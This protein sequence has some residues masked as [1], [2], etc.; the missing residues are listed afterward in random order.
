MSDT[1][2]RF[3]SNRGITQSTRFIHTPGD[4][5]LNNLLYVQEAGALKSLRPHTSSREGLESILF[6]II[7]DGEGFVRV[8]GNEYTVKS[9]DCILL[10]CM[11]KYEHESSE[12]KPWELSWVHFYG[13]TAVN[14]YDLFLK[15]NKNSNIFTP[16]ETEGYVKMIENLMALCND[17]SVMSEIYANETLTEMFTEIISD[18]TALSSEPSDIDVSMA[19]TYLNDNYA[20]DKAIDEICEKL[21]VEKEV[22]ENAFTDS[23]GISMAE[24]QK[25]RRL[26]VAKEMLRFS[27]EPESKIALECGINDYNDFIKLFVDAEG[28][29]PE[30]YRSKWAQW[31]K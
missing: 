18:V 2:S 21:G 20:S 29:T 6:I 4:F 28:M 24:Y 30:V 10:N 14:L 1:S 25:I 15:E 11:N 23:Y 13:K 5:A 7:K 3:F 26:N 31:I 8:S 12:S 16:T 19:R 27:I 9:G 22:V 17:K